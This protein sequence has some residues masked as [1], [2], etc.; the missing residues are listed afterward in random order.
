M[1]STPKSG[2]LWNISEHG[3]PHSPRPIRRD[4]IA[5]QMPLLTTQQALDLAVQHH[6]C[7]RLAEAKAC[8]AR[9]SLSNQTMLM[10]C[11]FW[12]ARHHAG[13]SDA[14]V[15]LLRAAIGLGLD[16]PEVHCNLG[17][18]LRTTGNWM[19]QSARSAGRSAQSEACGGLR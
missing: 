4:R 9:Y 3:S 12:I 5:R 16:N 11:I 7:G 19:K 13:H 18:A 1:S 6:Q 15:D 10:R 14:A 8:I 17:D 2:T